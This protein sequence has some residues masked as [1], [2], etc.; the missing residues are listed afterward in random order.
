MGLAHRAGR[1]PD[2]VA[3][4]ASQCIALWMRTLRRLLVSITQ[5]VETCSVFADANEDTKQTSQNN[6]EENS[7]EAPKGRR[8]CS[9]RALERART[10]AADFEQARRAPG[11]DG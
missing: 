4:L 7:P 1:L 6:K 2:G 5:R 10:R 11:L 3:R 9:A 8:F